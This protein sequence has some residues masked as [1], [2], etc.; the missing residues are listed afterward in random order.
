[1]KRCV[2]PLLIAAALAPAVT[3]TRASA[4]PIGPDPVPVLTCDHPDGV[5]VGHTLTCKVRGIRYI[6][7]TGAK[8]TLQPASKI[9]YTNPLTHSTINVFQATT[10]VVIVRDPITRKITDVYGVFTYVPAPGSANRIER[11]VSTVYKPASGHL[12]KA[13]S[14][15]TTFKV[16][17]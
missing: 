8:I 15:S 6:D 7:S 13:F 2:L 16:L 1:M 9:T 14:A 10:K 3:A 5:R 12:V 11:A 4:L 17:P